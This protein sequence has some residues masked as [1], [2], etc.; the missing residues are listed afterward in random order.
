MKGIPTI[1][2]FCDTPK[3]DKRYGYANLDHKYRRNVDDYVSACTSCHK[4][5]DMLFNPS[6]KLTT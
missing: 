5:Y 6:K 4:R 1:C 2:F 3:T